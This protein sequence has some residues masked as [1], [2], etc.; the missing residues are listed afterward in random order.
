MSPTV[1]LADDH[2][3]YREGLRNVLEGSGKFDVVAEAST[4]DEANEKI[5]LHR[6]RLVV[7]DLALGR[8]SGHTI[9]NYVQQNH[10]DTRVLVLSMSTDQRDV[11]HALCGGAAGYLT[12]MADHDELISAL[13]AISAGGSYIAAGLLEPVM[14]SSMPLL[15]KREEI[16]VALLLNGLT[17]KECSTKLGI[18][19]YT[20]KA[21]LR[22]IYRKTDT[23]GLSQLLLK[24]QNLGLISMSLIESVKE[25][26]AS[27]SICWK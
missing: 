17:A 9:I 16:L 25:G 12:K 8:T 20:V 10:P 22:A 24:S 5:G 6:P 2:P 26:L 13:T 1:I 19:Q 11:R 23:P 14:K 3:L 27:G 18:S 15:T 4:S 7:A 21:H